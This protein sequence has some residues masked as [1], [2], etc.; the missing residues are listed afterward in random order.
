ML[1]ETRYPET[2]RKMSKKRKK[3]DENSIFVWKTM[4]I[5]WRTYQI[6][7]FFVVEKCV[8]IDFPTF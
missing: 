3:T 6:F 5:M 1:W 2:Y 8:R 4:L 7:T